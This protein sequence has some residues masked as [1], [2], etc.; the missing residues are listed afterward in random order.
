VV[1][2]DDIPFMPDASTARCDFHRSDHGRLHRSIT[3]L[4]DRPDNARLLV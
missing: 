2:T 1:F 3:R 4:L